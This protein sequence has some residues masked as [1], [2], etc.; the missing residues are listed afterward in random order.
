MVMKKNKKMRLIRHALTNRTLDI[1]RQASLKDQREVE[2]RMEKELNQDQTRQRGLEVVLRVLWTQP[3]PTHGMY[4][5]KKQ[6]TLRSKRDLRRNRRKFRTRPT[7]TTMT[8]HLKKSK[9]RMS[10]TKSLL[11]PRV[12]KLGAPRAR[13]VSLRNLTSPPKNRQNRQTK[14]RNQ[15]LM[16]MNPMI[17]KSHEFQI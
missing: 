10:R 2:S 5:S 4:C 3:K 7:I 1:L 8:A 16:T 12:L 15:A 14:K 9:L 13:R 6:R 11:D 17:L